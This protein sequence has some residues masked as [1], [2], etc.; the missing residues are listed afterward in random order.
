MRQLQEQLQDYRKISSEKWQINQSIDFLGNKLSEPGMNNTPHTDMTEDTDATRRDNTKNASARGPKLQFK[1]QGTPETSKKREGPLKSQEPTTLLWK[2]SMKE[3]EKIVKIVIMAV[4]LYIITEK[5]LK[6]H[7]IDST[8][9]ML[10]FQE[11][12]HTVGKE[13]ARRSLERTLLPPEMIP[14]NTGQWSSQMRGLLK[15]TGIRPR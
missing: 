15:T 1:H 9:M 4:G 3:L 8:S 11:K 2:L 14:Y 6:G 5:Y 12:H 10:Q 7:L 13:T